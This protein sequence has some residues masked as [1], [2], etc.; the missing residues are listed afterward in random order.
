MAD[1]RRILV[2]DDDKAVRTQLG[3]Q[4]EAD[5]YDVTLVADGV[6][7]VRS[8]S[9]ELPDLMV[10]D[11]SIPGISGLDVLR[12]VRA[13]AASADLPVIILSGR[14][15]EGDRIVGLDAGADDYLIKP[16]SPGELAA[17][18]RSVLRRTSQSAPTS[19]E[20]K[21]TDGLNID[22]RSREVTIDG[23]PV[24]LTAKEFDLLAYLAAHPRQVFSRAQL[25]QTV[26]N[27]DGW[28]SEATVTEHIHRLRN[29]IEP[30]PSRPRWL[31]TVRGVGYRLEP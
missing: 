24:D 2:V 22:T 31:K 13:H 27:N 19:A 29:K 9:A 5:G 25:L 17:R 28:Q 20:S 21:D 11:L 4:L 26:W 10:L 1:R 12:T 3:W 18:V 14:S 6:E 30:D 8:I 16:F 23:E 15:S 7:A